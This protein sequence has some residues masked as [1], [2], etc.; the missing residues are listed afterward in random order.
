MACG[1]N[2]SDDAS[3]PGDGASCAT[4]SDCDDGV[5]CNGRERC[6]DSGCVSSSA[7]ACLPSQ[8]CDEDAARCWTTCAGAA[9]ADGDGRPA[10]ECGGDDCDDANPARHPGAAE[11]C[12][13]DGVDEDCDPVT[14]GFR[15]SDRDGWP[16]A[17]CCNGDNCGSDCDDQAP[18]VHPTEV[19]ACDALDND[20]DGNVDEEATATYVVDADGDGHG[21]IG[22]ATVEACFRPV[23][24]ASSA[25]DCDD[26][27]AS[28]HPGAVEDC[29]AED[30]DEDCDG[31]ANPPALC[32]CEP[33]ASRACVPGY[34]VCAAGTQDCV[35]GRWASC[36][37]RGTPETCDGEDDDCDDRIDEGTTVRCFDDSDGDGYAAA[38]AMP[39]DSLPRRGAS[40][41]WALPAAARRTARPSAPRLTARPPIRPGFPV[42]SSG[43]TG[44]I[45]TATVRRTTVR[46]SVASRTRTETGSPRSV[47]PR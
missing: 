3:V 14:Y 8:S 1:S 7:P 42:R 13:A 11:I 44:S 23:G 17:A 19:E 20:C 35:S 12:D 33:P 18:A 32:W 30:V 36:S 28:A 31:E 5:F 38:G 40:C 34:G 41:V 10:E 29:D 26:A 27:H 43:V 4:D 46:P 39:S 6:A 47:P 22:G 24:Y 9:D 37:I 15:D 45:R 16:D 25:D 21:A 2:G